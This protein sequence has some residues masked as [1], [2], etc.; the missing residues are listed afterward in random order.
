MT[1]TTTDIKPVYKSYTQHNFRQLPQMAHLTPE[2]IEDIDVVSHVLPFKS[3]NYVVDELINWDN[4]PDDPIFTLTF[5][6]KEMLIPRHYE[7]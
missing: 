6:R 4:V 3:N 2:Q 1:K 7:K 5:P